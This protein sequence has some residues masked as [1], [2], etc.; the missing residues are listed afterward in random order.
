MEKNA[1]GIKV[2]YLV[3]Y[4]RMASTLLSKNIAVEKSALNLGE[5]KYLFSGK[6]DDLLSHEWLRFKDSCQ[7]KGVL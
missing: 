5:M 3:G 1:K 4:G 2:Y 6:K 7:K